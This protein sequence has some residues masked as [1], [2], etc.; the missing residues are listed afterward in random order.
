M[1]SWDKDMAVIQR[2]GER[3]DLESDWDDWSD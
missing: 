2:E 3:A 1:W